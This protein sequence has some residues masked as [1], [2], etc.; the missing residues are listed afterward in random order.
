MIPRLTFRIGA[1]AS[2]SRTVEAALATAL[3]RTAEKLATL[4]PA[5]PDDPS[6]LPLITTIRTS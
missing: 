1:A 5:S 2:R 3:A 6:P 4:R